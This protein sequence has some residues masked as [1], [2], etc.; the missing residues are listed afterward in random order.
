MYSF[1]KKEQR[2]KAN[3]R[4]ILPFITPSVGHCKASIINDSD[5]EFGK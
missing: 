2:Y 1:I 4:Q 5:G 3:Q